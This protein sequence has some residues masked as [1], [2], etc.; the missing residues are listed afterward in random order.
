MACFPQHGNHVGMIEI[1]D[2][3]AI[4]AGFFDNA[5]QYRKLF[6]KRAKP[7]FRGSEIIVAFEALQE[8]CANGGSKPITAS[9]SILSPLC[10]VMV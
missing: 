9:S 7:D 3:V 10:R 1:A 5:L 4:G 6:Q 8:V 2:F